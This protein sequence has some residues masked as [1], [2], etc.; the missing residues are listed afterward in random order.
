MTVYNSEGRVAYLF[1]IS[2][3]FGVDGIKLKKFLFKA[4]GYLKIPK[5]LEGYQLKTYV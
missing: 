4:E 2:I 3:H 5:W 1:S